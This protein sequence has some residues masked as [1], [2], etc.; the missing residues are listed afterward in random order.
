MTLF[1]VVGLMQFLTLISVSKLTLPNS[2]EHG[3]VF[4]VALTHG[5]VDAVQVGVHAVGAGVVSR[6]DESCPFP[7]SDDLRPIDTLAM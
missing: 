6:F 5:G 4:C 2:T 1:K 3:R 7:N